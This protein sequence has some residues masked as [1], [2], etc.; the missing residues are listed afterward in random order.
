MTIRIGPSS[1]TRFPSSLFAALLMSLTDSALATV[2]YGPLEGYLQRSVVTEAEVVGRAALMPFLEAPAPIDACIAAGQVTLD[3]KTFKTRRAEIAGLEGNFPEVVCETVIPVDGQTD[4]LILRMRT[5]EEGQWRID[6]HSVLPESALPQSCGGTTSP[7]A[8]APEPGPIAR[9]VGVALGGDDSV[10]APDSGLRDPFDDDTVGSMHIESLALRA[11][12]W[13]TMERSGRDELRE[14][15]DTNRPR[16]TPASGWLSEDRSAFEDQFRASYL[17]A[18]RE[19]ITLVARACPIAASTDQRSADP[20]GDAAAEGRLKALCD[21]CTA[22]D[23]GTREGLVKRWLDPD[24]SPDERLDRLNLLWRI[25]DV[26]CAPNDWIDAARSTGNALLEVDDLDTDYAANVRSTLAG[27][28][29][30]GIDG[31]IPTWVKRSWEHETPSQTLLDSPS[32][33]SWLLSFGQSARAKLPELARFHVAR[34]WERP[35]PESRRAD[36]ARARQID[37]VLGSMALAGLAPEWVLAVNEEIRTLNPDPVAVAATGLSDAFALAKAGESGRL[38]RLLVDRRDAILASVGSMFGESGV[39]VASD[40]HGLFLAAA[41]GEARE[42]MNR[43][44]TLS[45]TC[46]NPLLGKKPDCAALRIVMA[47]EAIDQGELALAR[48]F[49][50]PFPGNDTSSDEDIRAT[51]QR[52]YFAALARLALEEQD[53]PTARQA[54][55]KT[56][57]PEEIDPSPI[58]DVIGIRIDLIDGAS[59]AAATRLERLRKLD[60]GTQALAGR[61]ASMHELD[62]YGWLIHRDRPRLQALGTTAA[63]EFDAV[64]KATRGGEAGSVRSLLNARSLRRDRNLSIAAAASSDSASL[65]YAESAGFKGLE[66]AVTQSLIGDHRA[67]SIPALPDVDALRSTLPD[68]LIVIDFNVFQRV[69]L[70]S[71]RN[72]ATGLL[73]LIFGRNVHPRVVDLGA[74]APIEA[75]I[76]ELRGKLVSR[77]PFDAEAKRLARDLF[78]PMT[79]ELANH[80]SLLVIP[81]DALNLVPFDVL[82]QATPD[83]FPG[84]VR[85]RSAGSLRHAF[86]SAHRDE[87]SAKFSDLVVVAAPEFGALTGKD[88]GWP[89]LPGAAEEGR[90]IERLW[91]EANRSVKVLA[92]ANASEQAV[93]LLPPA[94]LIHWATHGFAG[95][96]QTSGGFATRGLRVVAAAPI[97]AVRNTSSP[98]PRGADLTR[99]LSQYQDPLAQVG[100]VLADANHRKGQ[101]TDAD[102]ILSGTEVLALD[103]VGTRLVILSACD[104]GQGDIVRG[105]AMGSLKRAFHQ[106]GADAVVS[107]LWTIPDAASHVLLVAFHERLLAGDAPMEALEVA[108]R[109]VREKKEFSA[110]FF[111][112]GF[113]LSA[114]YPNTEGTAE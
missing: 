101:T 30:P 83:V 80:G 18:L 26:Q 29:T 2:P 43:L 91:S 104:T 68:D 87:P 42:V 85:I 61:I 111:W 72:D 98:V 20:L 47:N 23:R 52:D 15:L 113:Q 35:L 3:D 107:T 39:Q 6:C 79:A 37:E 74:F 96:P 8:S 65:A 93:R 106:A 17:A 81:D 38:Q 4:P 86:A 1:S 103:L 77:A 51:L 12:A 82:Q 109:Q 71:L 49:L 67:A 53:L 32:T 16:F 55:A 41:R 22:P 10:L 13:L 48:R 9:I 70:P 60:L 5:A 11:E 89:A 100:L 34:R 36:F 75:A 31:D 108:K 21:F 84:S 57:A 24:G 58:N 78:S 56:A 69:S 92:G 14:W 45:A 64:I 46:T 112:A 88:S 99:L 33:A 76:S 94:R 7:Q 114:P 110:P 19:E 95:K 27:L 63:S 50:T 90:T 40:M 73:A 28:G 102:G 62:V 25:N 105:N 97:S 66:E 44:E 54:F 59:G